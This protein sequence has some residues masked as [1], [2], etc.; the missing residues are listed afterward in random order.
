MSMAIPSFL[1]F[2]TYCVVNVY[3]PIFFRNMGY[4]TTTIG[5]LLA[6]LDISG[7]F[8]T[9][10][11][12]KFP[13]KSG[14]Y[15]LWLL[16]LTVLLVILPFPLLLLTFPV[17][18]VAIMLYA[19]PNKAFIPISDSFIHQRL[20]D[21]S[22]KYGMIRAF[23]SLGFVVMSLVMQYF[24][25]SDSISL[26]EG[27]L[28]MS[29]PAILLCVSLVAI[30]KLLKPLHSGHS[31]STNED[32]VETKT[33]ETKN[34][35][36]QFSPMYWLIIIVLTFGNFTQFGASKFF[37][38]YVKEYLHSDSFS[39]LWAI[40]VFFE[41]PG[42]F[43]SYKFIRRFGSR[44]VIVFGVA[45]ISLRS[46]MYVLFPSVLG[47]AVTQTLHAITFGLLHPASV[48]FIA[49]EVRG[50]KNA[51]MGQAISTVGSVG[52]ASILG[53][54][55]GGVIIDTYGYAQLYTIFGILPLVGLLIYGIF[56]KK[57]IAQN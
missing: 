55:I 1:F 52:V 47:A 29:V 56:R 4:S 44:K 2:S 19:I 18:V 42:L 32:F 43:F 35:F 22:D 17:T 12:C 53:S 27:A 9:F 11:I 40:S 24:V 38:L 10:F 41:I 34:F 20:G 57:A 13:E 15:G 28:W 7:I 5:V 50:T 33:S 51:V 36:K 16:L 49:E 45:V 48:I 25:N 46:F 39:L 14:K 8:F 31:P 6:L 21:K 23:G 37:S 3:F 30:P 26:F 54:F